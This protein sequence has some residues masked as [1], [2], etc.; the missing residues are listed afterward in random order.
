MFNFVVFKSMNGTKIVDKNLGGELAAL[1]L[2]RRLRLGSYFQ[3]FGP[4]YMIELTNLRSGLLL[5][6]NEMQL[7]S[8]SYDPSSLLDMHNDKQLFERPTLHGCALQN[9]S[10]FK[11]D[12]HYQERMLFSLN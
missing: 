10:T 2:R 1:K 6:W 4:R 3:K 5:R 11:D 9:L 12:P 8:L 7:Q